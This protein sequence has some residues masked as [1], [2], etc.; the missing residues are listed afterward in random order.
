MNRLYTL[1]AGFF[2]KM[3]LSTGAIQTFIT[4]NLI[5]T[6]L[7][8]IVAFGSGFRI[9][10]WALQGKKARK[11][12]SITIVPAH[13]PEPVSMSPPGIQIDTVLKKWASSAPPKQKRR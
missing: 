9:F 11:G 2:D 13:L 8:F 5:A 4:Q 10:M 12:P 3:N 1:V 6:S 7:M